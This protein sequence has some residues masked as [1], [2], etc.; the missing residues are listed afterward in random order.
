VILSIHVFLRITSR[1]FAA[2]LTR[3]LKIII[4]HEMEAQVCVCVCVC[5]CVYGARKTVFTL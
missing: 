5:V 2:A 4:L 1:H 3:S